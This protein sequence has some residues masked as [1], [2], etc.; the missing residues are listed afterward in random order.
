M[1]LTRR[2]IS[3]TIIHT[4][5]HGA[6]WR[7]FTTRYELSY[8][9]TDCVS[10]IKGSLKLNTPLRIRHN[11][12]KKFTINYNSCYLYCRIT[13]YVIVRDQE[14]FKYQNR[15]RAAF[16]SCS[17]ISERAQQYGL[18]GGVLETTAQN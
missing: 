1:A 9:I 3:V 16:Y 17:K 11:F 4:L 8:Y 10:S 7:V 15:R 5:P 13:L 18:G 12:N 6:R 14:Y 2:R